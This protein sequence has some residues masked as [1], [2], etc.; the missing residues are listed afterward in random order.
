[1]NDATVERCEKRARS[2]GYDGLVVVNLFAL[3]STFPSVL[4][5]VED[6]IGPDNDKHIL[7][8]VQRASLVVCAWG[9]HGALNGRAAHVLHLLKGTSVTAIRISKEGFPEHPLYLP[10]ALKPKHWKR[11][12]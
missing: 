10:Y 11:V 7:S 4:S 2:M 12:R 3:R 5:K 9:T 8:Q 1:V 6:P